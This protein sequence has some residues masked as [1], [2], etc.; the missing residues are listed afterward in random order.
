MSAVPTV[1]QI[2]NMENLKRNLTIL[3]A[4]PFFHFTK[5]IVVEKILQLKKNL[6]T[7]KIVN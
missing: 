7:I 5:K 4:K 3:T 6:S 1:L 2:R